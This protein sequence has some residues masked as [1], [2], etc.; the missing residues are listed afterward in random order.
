MNSDKTTDFLKDSELFKRGKLGNLYKGTP[1]TIG[2]VVQQDFTSA[3]ATNYLP[4]Y[5]NMGVHIKSGDLHNPV[6]SP[7]LMVDAHASSHI[8]KQI[9]RTRAILGG[10]ERKKGVR[11]RVISDRET[12][13]FSLGRHIQ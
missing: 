3:S 4:T 2:P 8:Y 7:P 1:Q 6:L 5:S 12:G 9:R 11:Y 13:P 10:M